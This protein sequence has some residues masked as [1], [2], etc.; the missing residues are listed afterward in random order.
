MSIM[1]KTL[2]H[3]IFPTVSPDDVGLIGPTRNGS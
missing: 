2:E 3:K 1:Y